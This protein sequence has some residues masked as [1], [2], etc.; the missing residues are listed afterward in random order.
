MLQRC[1][2]DAEDRQDLREA[3]AFYEIMISID[4]RDDWHALKGF[5]QLQ[6]H[7]LAGARQSFLAVRGYHA[8]DSKYR[9]RLCE[10]QMQGTNLATMKP[11]DDRGQAQVLEN[12]LYHL[13]GAHRSEE[14]KA[15][16]E[17]EHRKQVA[18]WKAQALRSRLM[19]LPRLGK[20]LLRRAMG[21][22]AAADLTQ[23]ERRRRLA[24]D[25]QLAWNTAQEFAERLV[26]WD[27]LG[28]DAMLTGAAQPAGGAED[29]RTQYLRMTLREDD[30]GVPDAATVMVMEPIEEVTDDARSGDDLGWVY[31]AISGERFSEA[32]SVIV[33]RVDGQPCIRSLQWGRP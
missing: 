19:M 1:V 3:I 26:R 12:F 24:P 32:V 4:A 18:R 11:P 28:A 23:E 2:Y 6:A 25:L 33:T 16:T 27:F 9:A 17:R 29:L 31:V 21:I 15:R 8:Q 13:E 5:A 30:G 7:D 20:R 22:V 10:L 14:A